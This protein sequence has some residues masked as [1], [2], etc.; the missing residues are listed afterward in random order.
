[1][2]RGFSMKLKFCGSAAVVL[3]VGACATHADWLVTKASRADG[4]IALSYERNEFQR[5]DLSDQ[6]AIQLA[7]QKCRNWGYKEAEPFGSQSTECLS[8]RGFGNCG[9]R[10]VTVEFQ[11]IGSLGK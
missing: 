9:S 6:Q 11:C 5:P 1:M 10:R 8:R 3:L 4:V 7:E 2:P